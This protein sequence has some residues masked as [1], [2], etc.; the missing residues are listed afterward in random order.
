M[1]TKKEKHRIKHNKYERKEEK[2][3]E[4]EEGNCVLV[5]RKKK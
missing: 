4:E 5:K 3:E 2:Q 1:K